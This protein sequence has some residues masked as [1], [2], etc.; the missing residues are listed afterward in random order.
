MNTI[1]WPE[2]LALARAPTPIEHLARLSAEVGADIFVKRDDLTGVALSGNKIRKLEFLFAE[3]LAR[4]AKRVYTCG[5]IQSNHARATAVAAARLGLS[6]LLFLRVRDNPPTRAEGNV[7]LDLL[8]GA[9][10]THITPREYRRADEIMDARAATEDPPAY[11]IPE[12]GSNALGALG[13]ARAVLEII[14]QERE[15]GITFD[16][17]VHAVGSGGTSAGLILG[18]AA[19]GLQAEVFGVNVCDDAAYFKTRIAGILK[20]AAERYAPTLTFT[21]DDVMILDGHVGPGYAENLPEDFDVIRRL[22]QGEGLFLDPV[23][24]GKA[25]KGL[26]AELAGGRLA[27]KRRILFVHTGGIFGLFPKADE[28]V[29]RSG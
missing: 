10:I 20:A 2:R 16:A 4:G 28:L 22:A 9:E 14:E 17:V 26:L 24:S 6:S 8:A 23:Y 19:F 29:R 21:E 25:M 3:A 5:G 7:L 12:G 11:V 13:Y 18:R 15:L 1:H 27:G